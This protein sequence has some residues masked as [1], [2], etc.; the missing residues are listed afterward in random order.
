MPLEILSE[1]KRYAHYVER[2]FLYLGINMIMILF[3]RTSHSIHDFHTLSSIMIIM[4]ELDNDNAV[5]DTPLHD[6][7]FSSYHHLLS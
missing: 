1:L 5:G 2:N 4:S 6:V 7:M 3:I